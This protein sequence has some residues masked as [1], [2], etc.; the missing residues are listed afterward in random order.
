MAL[1]FV[2]VYVCLEGSS[3]GRRGRWGSMGG[4]VRGGMVGLGGWGVSVALMRGWVV[5]HALVLDVGDVAVLVVSVIGHDLD[6][7]VGKSDAIL[8]GNNTV[9]ILETKHNKSL[10]K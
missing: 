7:A 6:T 2:D 8:A 1:W 5:G 3:M 9:L 4:W 10:N